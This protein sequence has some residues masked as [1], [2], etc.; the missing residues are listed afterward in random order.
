M[1]KPIDIDEHIRLLMIA[2]DKDIAL[3]RRSKAAARRML[4]GV[5]REAAFKRLEALGA[6]PAQKPKR[7]TTRTKSAKTA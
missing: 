4:K 5:S 2:M 3:A 7:R 1:T 6:Q